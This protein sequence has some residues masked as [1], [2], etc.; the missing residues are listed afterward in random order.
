[1]SRVFGNVCMHYAL[2]GMRKARFPQGFVVYINIF[3]FH[4]EY[5]GQ[6][7]I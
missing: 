2:L 4:Q 5:H 3:I 6:F 7:S 1:M